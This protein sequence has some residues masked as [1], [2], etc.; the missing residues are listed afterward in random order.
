[1]IHGTH[2]VFFWIS[3]NVILSAVLECKV[4]VDQFDGFFVE[5]FEKELIKPIDVT[6]YRNLFAGCVLMILMI[7]MLYV[8]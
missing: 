6:C 4:K 8:L 5:N 2:A 1:M 3:P 7:S